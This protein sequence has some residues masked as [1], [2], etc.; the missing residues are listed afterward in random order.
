MR[1]QL[2]SSPTAKEK[3]RSN[4]VTATLEI[5][6]PGMERLNDLISKMADLCDGLIDGMDRTPSV[7]TVNSVYKIGQTIAGLTRARTDL[8]K[9]RLETEG[10]HD[11]A[12]RSVQAHIRAELQGRPELVSELLE[13]MDTV[14]DRIDQQ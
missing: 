8:E 11:R 2:K 6:N 9:L 1:S 7:E 3:A 5:T 13:V 14:H 4:G 12:F 10:L